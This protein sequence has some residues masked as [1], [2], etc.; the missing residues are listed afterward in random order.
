MSTTLVVVERCWQNRR[1]GVRSGT[2]VGGVGESTT[3]ERR[4]YGKAGAGADG[5]G[6]GAISEDCATLAKIKPAQTVT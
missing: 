2:E 5:G 1:R 6:G 3:G 4:E